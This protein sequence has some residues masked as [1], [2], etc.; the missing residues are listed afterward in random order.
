MIEALLSLVNRC[1]VELI[2][3]IGGVGVAVAL[4]SLWQLM[5]QMRQLENTQQV[6]PYDQPA[7]HQDLQL[8]FQGICAEWR[9]ASMR[10][11]A[12]K[13]FQEVFLKHKVEK[14]KDNKDVELSLPSAGDLRE[15][16]LQSEL[17]GLA[18]SSLNTIVSFLLILGIFGTMAGVHVAL[19]DLGLDDIQNMRPALRPSMVAIMFTV[20]LMG[21]RALYA[22]LL[23]YYLIR[24]D[25]WT[26]RFKKWWAFE[27]PNSTQGL[28]ARV[29][30]SLDQLEGDMGGAICEMSK[31]R[32]EPLFSGKLLARISSLENAVHKVKGRAPDDEDVAVVRALLQQGSDLLNQFKEKKA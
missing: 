21:L 10:Q 2:F 20:A 22:A 17:S 27:E 8:K 16:S 25:E 19:R 32:T 9:H 13:S 12:L 14:A 30:D 26:A 28:L 5:R 3:L 24:L 31:W 6:I 18:P 11:M 7:A 4:F 15:M 23:D 29:V 1:I